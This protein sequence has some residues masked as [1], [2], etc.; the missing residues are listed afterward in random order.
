V[1][2][3]IRPDGLSTHEVFS[4]VIYQLTS[5]EPG[6]LTPKGLWDGLECFAAYGDEIEPAVLGT[7]VTTALGIAADHVGLVD[8]RKIGDQWERSGG[9]VSI[10]EGLCLELESSVT[11]P[12]MPEIDEMPNLGTDPLDEGL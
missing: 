6:T 1:A 5:E 10:I 4:S 9:A 7:A 2:G 8:H 12:E 11:T 3:Y